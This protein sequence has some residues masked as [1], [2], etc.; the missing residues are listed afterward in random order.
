MKKWRYHS[1][2]VR[3]LSIADSKLNAEGEKGWEL[4]N[5]CLIDSNSARC[6][7]KQEVEEAESILAE[8]AFATRSEPAFAS[9]SEPP[10]GTDSEAVLIGTAPR[11]G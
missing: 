3:D 7:F 4:I 1:L 10:F 5:V 6:F 11:F 2:L 8:P 9:L